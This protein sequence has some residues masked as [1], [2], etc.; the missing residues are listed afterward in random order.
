MRKNSV[1]FPPREG[2]PAGKTGT[3]GH[4]KARCNMFPFKW[5]ANFAGKT[6]ANFTGAKQW[7]CFPMLSFWWLPKVMLQWGCSCCWNSFLQNHKGILY[8][9]QTRV[10]TSTLPYDCS[11]WKYMPVIL[12]SAHFIC[13]QCLLTH[14]SEW[15]QDILE[16]YFCLFYLAGQLKLKVA[17]AI[18]KGR[19]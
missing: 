15:V 17:S 14:F 4:T 8:F 18:Q 19:A 11:D 6:M 12:P 13:L 1:I 9:P 16:G 3:L 2:T 7:S 5:P 10:P